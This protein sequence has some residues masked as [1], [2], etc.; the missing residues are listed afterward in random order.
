CRNGGTTDRDER[1]RAQRD[2]TMARRRTSGK[3]AIFLGLAACEPRGEIRIDPA[4]AAVGTVETV[5]I[6]T[7]R[8]EVPGTAVEYGRARSEVTRFARIDVSVPPRSEEHT[9]ELQS[10]ENLVCRL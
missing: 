9:S 6:G 7:T 10:R 8:G 1:T 3:A 5:F 2:S 4:A